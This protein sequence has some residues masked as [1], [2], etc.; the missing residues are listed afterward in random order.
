MDR[1]LQNEDGDIIYAK[2][3][4]FVTQEEFEKE[5]AKHMKEL[6]GSGANYFIED[7]TCKTYISS[8]EGLPGE[9]LIEIENTDIE[10]ITMYCG[11]VGIL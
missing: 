9:S 2:K 8:A 11:S 1:F 5:A 10:I 7:V 3:N 4:D 6:D